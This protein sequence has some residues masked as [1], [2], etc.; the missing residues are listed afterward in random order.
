VR[1]VVT[2]P[3]DQAEP[4]AARLRD[5]GH[6]VVVCPLIEIE[7]LGDDPI[8]VASYD[9]VVVTS[10]N[11]ANELARRRSGDPRQLAA[12]GP[13]TAEALRSHGLEPDVVAMT[14]TQEGVVAALP[15]EP[16]RVLVAAAEG[17]R[18]HLA[19]AVGA[20]FLPLYRTRE[21][22]PPE[23][24]AGDLVVLASASAAR[25][26][27]H[28]SAPIPAVSIGPET[29]RAAREAGIDVVSEATPHTLDGLVAAVAEAATA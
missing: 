26:F 13:G 7:P 17:A 24:P 22:E 21:L 23:P 18:T 28:L 6:D 29:T 15:A 12:I 2:R 5:L 8:E 4:L 25:A 16:G 3:A 27:A 11:G 20:E 10:P 1:I 19:A 9:W 14:S